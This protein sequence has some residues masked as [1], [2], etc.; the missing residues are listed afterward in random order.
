M[1]RK[2]KEVGED[3]LNGIRERIDGWHT[4]TVTTQSQVFGSGMLI[5]VTRDGQSVEEKT[6]NS[7]GDAGW[8]VAMNDRVRVF[9][10][11]VW[12]N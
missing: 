7:T 5:G 6:E 10:V 3:A 1:P 9:N 4:F 11:E 12:F 2:K 8:D